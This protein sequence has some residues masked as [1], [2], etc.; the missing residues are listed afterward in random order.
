MKKLTSKL[1]I[2]D[3]VALWTTCV[4]V[5]LTSDSL[6]T[7]PCCFLIYDQLA[8]YIVVEAS[9]CF[10]HSL[11]QE[12]YIYSSL[13]IDIYIAVDTILYSYALLIDLYHK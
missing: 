6:S 12:C 5:C 4:G 8:S 11:S 1:H 13:L 3:I 2:S 9:L 10:S 7:V